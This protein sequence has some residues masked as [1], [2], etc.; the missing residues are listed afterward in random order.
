MLHFPDLQEDL[1]FN[2]LMSRAQRKKRIMEL[3]YRQK[4]IIKIADL[5]FSKQLKT[6]D[7]EIYTYCGTPLNM[8]PEVMRKQY[9]YKADIWSIGVILFLLITGVYP[10]FARSK[11]QLQQNIDKGFYTI[12][13]QLTI[14]PMCLD[15]INRC[16]Q[17]NPEKRF[18]WA[19]IEVHPFY[20]HKSYYK[21]L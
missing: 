19:A 4:F 20:N 8:A 15:F 1:Y 16:L 18:D 10:F 7:E 2:P 12:N 5:G 3:L 6:L 9:N 14:T 21:V 17:Y 11:Q 13:R